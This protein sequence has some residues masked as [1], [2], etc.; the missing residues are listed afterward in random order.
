[1]QGVVG[2]SGQD[3]VA[4]VSAAIA[5][6]QGL[7]SPAPFKLSG[8]KEALRVL[9]HYVG[10]IHQPLHVAAVYLDNNGH[11]VDPDMGT[12]DP[13]TETRGGNDL[14]IGTKSLH[15]QWDGV[16]GTFFTGPPTAAVLK[17]SK[18][19]AKT[20]G[21]MTQWAAAWATETLD[22]GKNAYDGIVFS[23]ENA[24]HRYTVTLPA[25]YDS[26]RANAQRDQVV[27]AGAR[28]AQILTE[29]WPD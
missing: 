20:S 17:Q 22:L 14:L 13:R 27:N 21:P 5:V 11:V 8:K 2:T 7:P 12:F 3:I 28:L 6:L 19:V 9:V 23:S 25:G 26:K 4:A 15:G 1:M 29:T 24:Q 16:S 10:D 18:S